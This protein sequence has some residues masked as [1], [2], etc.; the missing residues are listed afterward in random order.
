MNELIKRLRAQAKLTRHYCPHEK[1]KTLEEN[2][3]D[4]IEKLQTENDDLFYTLEGVMHSVDKWLDDCDY[5]PNRVQRAAT[6][7]E[8]TLQIVERLQKE[9]DELAK[10]LFN[11]AVTVETKCDYCKHNC[12]ITCGVCSNGSKWEWRGVKEA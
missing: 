10:E 2:A 11:L 12:T 8:K 3:A 5:S 1:M 7:R 6:M 9:R 4:A